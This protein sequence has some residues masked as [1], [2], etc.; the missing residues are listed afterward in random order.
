MTLFP[1]LQYVTEARPPQIAIAVIGT[2]LTCFNRE[3]AGST[4]ASEVPTALKIR[5][6]KVNFLLIF[7][8]WKTLLRENAAMFR[9]GL[10]AYTTWVLTIVANSHIFWYR[11]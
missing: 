10:K 8:G 1:S 9:L 5:P 11:I 6:K 4:R 7:N 3:T 2:K